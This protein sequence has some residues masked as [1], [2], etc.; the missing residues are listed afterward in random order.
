[1]GLLSIFERIF[2]LHHYL[3]EEE[4]YESFFVKVLFSCHYPYLLRL[5]K[6]SDKIA[7]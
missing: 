6:D 7:E 3:K 2:L 4:H 5:K 1:V